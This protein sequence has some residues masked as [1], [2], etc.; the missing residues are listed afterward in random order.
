MCGFCINR[1]H[2][3]RKIYINNNSNVKGM[4]RRLVNGLLLLT[5]ATGSCSMFTSCKDTDEDWK[6]QVVLGQVSLEDRIEAL[7]DAIKGYEGCKCDLEAVKEALRLEMDLKIANL[8]KLI[9]E[10]IK[11]GD[12][13]N[14]EL[15]EKNIEAIN[16]LAVKIADLEGKYEALE[17]TV[18]NIQTVLNSINNNFSALNE[19]FSTLN[20]NQAKLLELLTSYQ[21]MMQEQLSGLNTTIAGLKVDLTKLEDALGKLDTTVGNIQTELNTINAT[22]TTKLAEVKTELNG[23]ANKLTDTNLKLDAMGTKLDNVATKVGELTAQVIANEA[24]LKAL[25]KQ[26]DELKA[27]LEA[28]DNALGGRI[29]VLEEYQ[30]NTIEPALTKLSNLDDQ[31]NGEDGIAAQLKKALEDIAENAKK[32]A[33]NADKIQENTDKIDQNSNDIDQLYGMLER[34]SEQIEQLQNL[35]SLYFSALA[36]RLNSLITGIILNQTW[37]PLFGTINLPLGIETTI[38]ANYYGESDHNLEFPLGS[39]AYEYNGTN[40]ALMGLIDDIDAWDNLANNLKDPETINFH[41]FNADKVN[42]KNQYVIKSNDRYMTDVDNNLGQLYLTINPNNIDFSNVNLTLVNSMDEPA[43]IK[44]DVKKCNDEVLTFGANLSRSVENNGFYRANL[45]VKPADATQIRVRIE[46]G[47]KSSMKDALKER[48]KGDLA[49]FGK[50]LVDQLSGVLP[51]YAIK[52]EWEAPVVEKT[53]NGNETVNKKYATYSDYNIAATTFQPLGYSFLYGV[54]FTD[55]TI[56]GHHTQLPTYGGSLEELLDK[57]FDDLHFDI[58]ID[59]GKVDNIT[60]D[61]FKV[62]FDLSKANFSFDEPMEIEIKIDLNGTVLTTTQDVEGEEGPK[63]V[64]IT[65]GGKPGTPEWS[66]NNVITT[67]LTYNPDGTVELGN[68]GELNPFVDAIKDAVNNFIKGTGDDSLANQINE[69]INNQL[70]HKLVDQVNNIIDQINDMLVGEE[71]GDN[72]INGQIQSAIQDVISQIKNTLSGKLG[73]IDSLIDKYNSLAKRVNKILSQPN[74]YLQVMM[75]YEDGTGNLHHLSTNRNV[76]SS[77]RFAGGDAI[78]LFMTSYTAELIAPS[79]AKYVAVSRV[80]DLNGNKLSDS[81][82]LAETINNSNDYLNVLLPGTLQRVPLGVKYL[83]TDHIYEVV[84]SSVD[85]RGY[86]SSRLYY[87]MVTK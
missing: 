43:P 61:D 85:Y 5:L 78:E 8:Q 62:E 13:A 23:I 1:F 36:D 3:I 66:E 54:D 70:V 82:T 46:E 39:G 51:A 76:P 58:K 18:G 11:N 35:T 86:T 55:H 41:V 4:N 72:G 87:F 60:Y 6:N 17:L 21:T 48:T 33:E 25:Q 24:A 26:Y 71:N 67:T 44:L 75:A 79:F 32:I 47:L 7:E 37:N 49:R 65:I 69:Q 38:A 42:S 63:E 29:T 27:A 57:F 12:E 53:E 74:H 10:D 45:K 14:K 52:A 80:F 28:A 40:S 64:E 19:N 73:K 59:L 22:L 56:G 83:Q 30:K 50:K 81:E 20:A 2:S 16:N 9:E 15:I 31:I 77:F 84:L 34:H 68:M